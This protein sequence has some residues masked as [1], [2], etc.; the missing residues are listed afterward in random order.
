MCVYVCVLSFTHYYPHRS[1]QDPISRHPCRGIVSGLILETQKVAVNVFRPQ[2]GSYRKHHRKT[3]NWL[4]VPAFTK[5]QIIGN[6]LNWDHPEHLLKCLFQQGW[7][8]S[9]KKTKQKTSAQ[10]KT[11]SRFKK[12][13][14]TQTWASS[15]FENET[16]SNNKKI[17]RV[18]QRSSS[19]PVIPP[20][21]WRESLVADKVL[22]LSG[23]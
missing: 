20:A 11:T 7:V 2:K 22:S 10:N 5:S 12:K 13:K 19:F 16:K 8:S 4:L 1:G 15:W 6:M 21:L 14:K 3:F 9:K 18:W 23:S 17:S